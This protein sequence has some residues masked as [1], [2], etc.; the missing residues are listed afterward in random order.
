MKF[1]GTTIIV[2]LL[3]IIIFFQT[4]DYINKQTDKRDVS[5]VDTIFVKSKDTYHE[6]IKK[7]YYPVPYKVEIPGTPGAT[8]TIPVSVDSGLVVR[9][10]FSKHTYND[11]IKTDSI[12]IYLKDEVYKNELKRINVGYKILFPTVII[13]KTEIRERQIAYL[14][15]DITGNQ[16][17]LGFYPS[18][19][20]DTKRAMYG[21][22]YDIINKYY[23]LGVYGKLKLWKRKKK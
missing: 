17:H 23:K 11:S 5:T 21:G 4:C 18:F 12:A 22:G 10:Y 15:F 9:D 7:E 3:G 13:T 1:Y 20:F 16:N 6:T 8:I 2:I 19:Y 14:G